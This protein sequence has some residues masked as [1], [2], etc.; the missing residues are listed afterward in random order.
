MQAVSRVNMI[1]MTGKVIAHT[2]HIKVSMTN[3][4]KKVPKA[5]HSSHGK[6]LIPN[7]VHNLVRT[8]DLLSVFFLFF[9]IREDFSVINFPRLVLHTA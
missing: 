1:N 8:Y 3:P 7:S 6:L 9:S 2:S 4:H 5:E